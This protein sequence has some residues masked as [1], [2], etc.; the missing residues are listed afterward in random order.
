MVHH[1][2]TVGHRQRFFLVVGDHDR[3]HPQLALQ[4]ADLAAQAFAHL[5]IEGG[6]RLVEQQQAGLGGQR[7]RE[8]DALLLAARALR[9]VLGPGVGQADQGQ[10][11]L[12]PCIHLG[13]AL[14]AVT[15]P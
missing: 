1:H 7:T 11:F 3:S 9:R 5:G 14:A 8:R 12:H 10:Q 13:A 4:C 6:E 2:H 15:R